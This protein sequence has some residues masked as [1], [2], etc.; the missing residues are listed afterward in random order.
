[1]NPFEVFS[2]VCMMF[3]LACASFALTLDHMERRRRHI[4]A[5]IRRIE[6]SDPVSLRELDKLRKLIYQED[7]KPLC[8]ISD[9][10]L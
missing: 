10:E 5:C 1:M 2:F 4:A 8:H 7:G 6:F 9:E 3:G